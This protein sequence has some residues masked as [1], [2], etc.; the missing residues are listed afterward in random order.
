MFK[1]IV[2]GLDDSETSENALQTACD[3]AL[4]Y[5]AELH[6][7]HTPTSKHKAFTARFSALLPS[8]LQTYQPCSHGVL[9]EAALF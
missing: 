1:K 9:C 3:L 7:V 6:L 8:Q 5:D 2:V 4:K